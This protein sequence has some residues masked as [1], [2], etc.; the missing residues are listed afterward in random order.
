M[1]TLDIQVQVPEDHVL[2]KRAELEAVSYTHL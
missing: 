2:I 1:Q